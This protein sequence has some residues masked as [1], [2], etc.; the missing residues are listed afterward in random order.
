MGSFFAGVK[1][2]TLAGAAYVGGMALFNVLL[3][4]AFK[5][6]VLGIIS[7][8]FSQVCTPTAGANATTIAVE[9]CFNSVIA[10]YVPFV[11]F[12]AFFVTLAF[13]GVFGALYELFPGS[14]PSFRGVTIGVATGIALL[15]LNL[16]G[17]YFDFTAKVA[18]LSF[19]VFMTFAY[20]VMMG[21]L[22]RRYTR[23]V[24][25][26]VGTPGAL[27]VLVDNRDFTGK[28]RTFALRSTHE[29]RAEAAPG[30]TFREWAASGGVVLED[31]RSFETTMDIEG[32]GVLKGQS[33]ARS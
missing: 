7:A 14:R 21:K 15:V 16:T 6:D 8:Q 25:F 2:G 19:F 26:D 28:T 3:L 27:R 13:A 32:D 20:G 12:L 30:A 11:A 18:V 23:E 31:K 17:I 29:V 4:Y 33:A 5:Q 10:V 24:R 9:D 1:A 22:Y